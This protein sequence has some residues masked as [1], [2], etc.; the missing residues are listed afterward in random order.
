MEIVKK[1]FLIF[2]FPLLSC[3]DLGFY[4]K[5]LNLFAEDFEAANTSENLTKMLGL[6]ALEGM[7]PKDLS[8]LKTAL[9][10]EL[11]IP[12]KCIHFERLNGAP[13]E[14]IDF[15][16]NGL[17]YQSSITPIYK[18]IVAYQTEELFTS[19]FTIGKDLDNKWKI[20]TAIP[21]KK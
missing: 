21:S 11:G 10:F 6:Y 5:S 18:M 19:R 8:I 7:D 15:H 2:L 20:I 13:E 12:I 4:Q 17:P 9:S 1:K 14:T 16:H 3:S